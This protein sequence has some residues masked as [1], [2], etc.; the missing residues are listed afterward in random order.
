[1]AIGKLFVVLLSMII[2]PGCFYNV[3]DYPD[4]WG[5]LVTE[6]GCPDLNGWYA[7]EGRAYMGPDIIDRFI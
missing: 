1:M 6:R 4:E 5:K 3:P 2:L 7:D